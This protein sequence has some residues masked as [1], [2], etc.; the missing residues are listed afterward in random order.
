[1]KIGSI[2]GSTRLKTIG[3]DFED[4][5]ISTCPSISAD[6]PDIAYLQ[7]GWIYREMPLAKYQALFD[8]PWSGALDQYRAEEISFSPDLYQFEACIAARSNLPF[9]EGR[10]HDLSD[11]RHHTDKKAVFEAFGLNRDLNYEEDLKLHLASDWKMK[12]QL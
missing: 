12:Y 4:A 8:Q 2:W 3:S 11:P 10:Q 1:M 5:M 7:Y 9:Y 6:D